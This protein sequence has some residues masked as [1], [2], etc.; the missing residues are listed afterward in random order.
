MEDIARVYFL[1]ALRG[2]Y[3]HSYFDDPMIICIEAHQPTH[4]TQ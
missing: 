3:L 4:G 2:L 1:G